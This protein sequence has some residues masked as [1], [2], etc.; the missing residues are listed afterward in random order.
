[1]EID[2]FVDTLSVTF[3]LYAIETKRYKRPEN[4][5]YIRTK[6]VMQQRVLPCD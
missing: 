6:P 5:K 3:H 1:M 4:L 2:E